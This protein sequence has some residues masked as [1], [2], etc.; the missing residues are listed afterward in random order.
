MITKE[1]LKKVL[2]FLG[3]E[4]EAVGEYYSKIYSTCSVHV[5]F[6][7]E[8]LIYPENKGLVIN[9]KTTSNFSHNENFVVFEC[10]CR[11]LSKGY[12]PEH[13]ELEPKWQLGR[14]AKSGKADIVVKDENGNAL[15]IIECKTAGAEYNKEVKKHGR[16]WRSAVQLLAA[17]KCYTM[18]GFVFVRLER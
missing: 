10:V 5:D 4:K 18:V 16:I 11:L 17:R 6:D 7:N 12:R 1:N 9:D 3:F 13:I 8:A 2:S 14:D 15:L